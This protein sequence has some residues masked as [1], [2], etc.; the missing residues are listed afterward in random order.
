MKCVLLNQ[1]LHKEELAGFKRGTATCSRENTESAL[2]SIRHQKVNM[3]SRASRKS[4]CSGG[5][6]TARLTKKD[7]ACVL[8]SMVFQEIAIPRALRALIP[9]PKGSR[10]H[11][12]SKR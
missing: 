7:A 8:M 10:G 9:H 12:D 1:R 4:A 11:E 3:F 5:T 2:A 6:T